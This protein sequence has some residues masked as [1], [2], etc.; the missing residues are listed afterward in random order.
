MIRIT[1]KC[2]TFFSFSIFL[3][4]MTSHAVAAIFW[5]ES[6]GSCDG[7]Y[8]NISCWKFSIVPGSS[9][10][11]IWNRNHINPYTV[12]FTANVVNQR[13]EIQGRAGVRAGV[14]PAQATKMK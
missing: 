4:S 14:G 5:D 9:D 11:A 1:S 6:S 7:H 3:L 13:A 10:I 12:T 2:V 8:L